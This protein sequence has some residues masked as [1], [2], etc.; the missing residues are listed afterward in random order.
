[1]PVASAQS[2]EGHA[3][4]WHRR[5]QIGFAAAVLFMV[6]SVEVTGAPRGPLVTILA[7]S[8]VI[9]VSTTVVLG[10]ADQL[11]KDWSLL[12]WPVATIVTLLAYTETAPDAGALVIGLIPVVFLHI[13]LSQPP[14]RGL[15]LL[16]PA[17][18][19]YAMA[20]DMTWAEASVWMPIAVVAWAVSSELPARLID[21]LRIQHDSLRAAASTDPLTGLL[22][23]STLDACVE[24]APAGSAIAVID[25]DHFKQYNDTHGHIAGDVVLADFATVLVAQSRGLDRIFRFGGEEFLVIFHATAVPEAASVVERYA[26][27]WATHVSGLSFSAGVTSLAGD[28]IRRADEL[29]YRAK[30]D[31]RNRVV[32]DVDLDGT[33]EVTV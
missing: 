19:S 17:A 29:L 3:P 21:E 1:L 15:W 25:I 11:G 16:A 4:T 32:V 7:T 26:R 8:V 24:A 10:S 27:S 6:A 14:R 5:G 22:N 28:G 20:L 9:V 33:S 12:L 18:V 31:G 30:R 13:G 23:R 2:A